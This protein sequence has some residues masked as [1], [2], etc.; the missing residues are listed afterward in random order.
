MKIKISC[1]IISLSVFIGLFSFTAFAE[2]N[3]YMHI[4]YA[5]NENPLSD[6]HF[7]LYYLG[8]DNNGALQPDGAFASYRCDFDISGAE[9]RKLLAFTLEAYVLRDDITA[10]YEGATDEN[11]FADF[12]GALLPEGV[13]LLTGEKHCQY[14]KTYEAQPVIMTLP[15]G[16]ANTVVIKPKYESAEKTEGEATTLRVMK[17]WQDNASSDRPGE[18]EVQLL[19]DGEIFDSVKLN[20]GNFWEYTW[21]NLDAL[22]HW[23]VTEKDVDD[24]YN[25]RISL[26]DNTFLI[27]NI[28]ESD[29]E[30]ST[31][32]DSEKEPEI[33]DTGMLMWPIPYLA[34]AGLLIFIIGFV[35]YRKSEIK[36]GTKE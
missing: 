8:T 3:Q 18:I 6:A 12:G 1:L 17:V 14:D 15:F 4:I 34:L 19:K 30:E 7:S 33:P 11:G 23:R 10:L 29:E 35:Y 27:T 26:T 32:P 24:N 25:V 22:S 5:D 21:T 36:N 9:E 13:Y 31:E 20:D 28:K 2:E 16:E